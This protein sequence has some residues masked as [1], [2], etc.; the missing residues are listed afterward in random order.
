M[1]IE[2][3]IS[4]YKKNNIKIFIAVLILLAAWFTYDGYFNEKFIA[5]HTDEIQNA[6]VI[7]KKADDTLEFN[8]KAPPFLFAGALLLAGYLYMIKDIK[9]TA[10]ENEIVLA[11]GKKIDYDSIQKINKTY[12]E[13]KGYF[14]ITYQQPDGQEIDCKL[15]NR[16]YDNLPAVL[17]HLVSKIS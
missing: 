9:I 3:T 13:S 1:V 6:D 4:K 12:F 15:S 17:D 16:K 5:N 11:K 7:E 8:R 14:T 2:A 10:N